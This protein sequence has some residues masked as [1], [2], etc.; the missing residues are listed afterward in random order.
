MQKCCAFL[1]MEDPSGYFVYDQLTHQPLASLGWRVVDVPWTKPIQPWAQFDAVVVRSPWDYQSNPDAFLT[2]LDS[3][4]AA[5]AR[6]FNP[7]Q[8]CRWNIDKTYLRDLAEHGVPTIPTLWLNSFDRVELES[9]FKSLE[10]SDSLVI[11]PTIGAGA[12]N[13]FVLGLPQCTQ[14]EKAAQVFRNRPL[15][16]QPFLRS[17][18]SLGEYSLFYFAGRFSH[19]I[20]KTP[21]KGD[22]RV[23]EEHG[24]IIRSIEPNSEILAVGERTLQAIDQ[25]L[26]Y[27]RVDIVQL[28]DGSFAV[29][30]L[31]LIEPS[32]YF[33]Y[34][35]QSPRRFAEALNQMAGSL[36]KGE[37]GI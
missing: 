3:I 10:L 14:W 8:I 36:Q 11:K 30:E 26:L 21:A 34:D 12:D 15:M 13:V 16:V 27:A 29:I 32:L 31:E 7:A 9:Q 17:I 20:I 5:G 25:Q 33:P 24:G 37:R 18:V 19:A 35:D 4:E 28:Q 23:Q 6:L 2:T 22:F 1:T